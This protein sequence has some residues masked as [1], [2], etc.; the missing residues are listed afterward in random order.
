MDHMIHIAAIS[1]IRLDID[2]WVY[3]R[4]KQAEGAFAGP[5]AG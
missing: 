4:R 5:I 3:S 2:G 1:Q